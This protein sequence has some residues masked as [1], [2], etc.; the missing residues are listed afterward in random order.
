[1]RLK[2]LFMV[3]IGFFAA[4]VGC[5]AEHVSEHSTD[6]TDRR[7][8]NYPPESAL[9]YPEDQVVKKEFEVTTQ[10]QTITFEKPLKINRKG[11]MGL[12]LVVDQAP[13]ISTT[14]DDPRNLDCSDAEYQKNAFSLRRRSDGVLVRPEV[15]L[16]GDNGIETEVRP[17]GHL[18]PYFDKSIITIALRTFKDMDSPS[19]PFPK[20]IKAFTAIRIRSTE[21]FLVRYMWWSVDRYPFYD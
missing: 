5:N 8:V 11:L 17:L 18:Y 19:P 2:I 10:W 6:K 14:G 13:Y 7:S 9:Q 12:H 16:I 4:A 20:N 21:P 1:M 15:S 3:L